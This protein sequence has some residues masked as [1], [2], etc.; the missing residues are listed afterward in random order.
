MFERITTIDYSNAIRKDSSD[1]E[2]CQNFVNHFN[3]E[4]EKL[5]QFIED[6]DCVLKCYDL[7]EHALYSFAL[8]FENAIPILTKE[9]CHFLSCEVLSHYDA[10]GEYLKSEQLSEAIKLKKALLK[11]T[12]EKKEVE[13]KKSKTSATKGDT[14]KEKKNDN[15]NSEAK[16]KNPYGL[17]HIFKTVEVQLVLRLYELTSSVAVSLD[18][19][20][21]NKLLFT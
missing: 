8:S 7:I 19:G 6:E 1:V 16:N 20:I 2:A 13:E 15:T 12:A 9:L 10:I 21:R 18:V 3:M 5:I 14:N 17:S 4:Y 11:E